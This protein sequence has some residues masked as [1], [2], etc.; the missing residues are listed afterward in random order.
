MAVSTADS[1]TANSTMKSLETFLTHLK[2]RATNN[3]RVH[4]RLTAFQEAAQ[5]ENY[6]QFIS[7][8]IIKQDERHCTIISV[9]AKALLASEGFALM[10]SDIKGAARFID[11]IY[12]WHCI[13]V[14]RID[15][16]L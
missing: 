1:F 11:E 12:S 10:T 4:E 8:P 14:L 16:V 7:D 9:A 3:I 2:S 13:C 5:K 15:F 6:L